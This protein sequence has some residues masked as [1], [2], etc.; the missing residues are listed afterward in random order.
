ML[1]YDG[2]DMYEFRTERNEMIV[3]S[4][5][6]IEMIIDEAEK[7]EEFS[8]GSKFVSMKDDR[9]FYMETLETLKKEISKLVG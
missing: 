6:D 1:Q 7:H 5:N 3:L 2:L 4:K 8:L 9:D